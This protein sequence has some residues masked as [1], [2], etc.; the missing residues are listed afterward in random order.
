[1][2]REGP[3]SW[4][5]VIPDVRRRQ[6]PVTKGKFVSSANTLDE[7]VG[8][9]ALKPRQRASS[10]PSCKAGL[11][12]IVAGGTQAE[13]ATSSL[14]HVL[15]V[16]S[17]PW[18]TTPRVR[19]RRPPVGLGFRPSPRSSIGSYSNATTRQPSVSSPALRPV[20]AWVPRWYSS[21]AHCCWSGLCR[22]NVSALL[23]CVPRLLSASL[24]HLIARLPARR[25]RALHRRRCAS[26]SR[27]RC[28]RVRRS[29]WPRRR[30]RLRRVQGHLGRNRRCAP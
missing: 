3:R 12:V 28:H 26:R 29:S 30:H 1:M 19:G 20:D 14:G 17:V 2:R 11:N 21:S 8:L 4:H 16:P 23:L 24:R 9:G 7:L 27:W 5:A 6:W 15:P 22:C 18:Q 25:G 13:N 10:R